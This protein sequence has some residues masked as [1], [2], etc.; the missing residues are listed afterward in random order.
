MQLQRF[1]EL[2]ISTYLRDTLMLSALTND[3]N[4]AIGEIAQQVLAGQDQ[5]MIS[6]IKSLLLQG[7]T[8]G[9]LRDITSECTVY[10][11]LQLGKRLAIDELEGNPQYPLKDT[12]LVMNELIALG[13][14]RREAG[15][16]E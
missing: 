14:I 13:L 1:V 7:I 5:A 6:I 15:A 12:F 8:A 2:T 9:E 11:M 16:H 4:G 3:L 10:L